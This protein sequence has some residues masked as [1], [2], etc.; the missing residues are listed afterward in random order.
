MNFRIGFGY[1]VHKLEKGRDLIIGGVKIPSEKGC[2]AHS[3]GDVLIHAIIDAMLGA[4]NMRD[5]GFHFPDNDSN[6]KNI[7]SK[8]LLKNALEIIKEKNWDIN[9]IDCTV[10]LQSPKISHY[11]DNMKD[12]ISKTLSIEPGQIS[13]KATTTENLGFVGEKKG[14]SAY[15]IILIKSV[16]NT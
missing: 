8:I 5:I 7:D 14:I 16:K 11:I 13:I 6:Y 3:D 2:I 10:C 9:N 12:I 4:A 15:A 1:D